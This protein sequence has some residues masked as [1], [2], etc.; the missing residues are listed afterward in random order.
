M[1]VG[2]CANRRGARRRRA[3]NSTGQF[4]VCKGR[5]RKGL[6]PCRIVSPSYLVLVSADRVEDANIAGAGIAVIRPMYMSAACQPQRKQQADLNRR[7]HR[8]ASNDRCWSSH[9][10][11]DVLHLPTHTLGS[12]T[13]PI[14]TRKQSCFLRGFADRPLQ[15]TTLNRDCRLRGFCLH[16][17]TATSW[18]PN[19]KKRI[20]LMGGGSSTSRSQPWVPNPRI[21]GQG[22]DA[23][24]AFDKLLLAQA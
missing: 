14:R 5:R 20:P 16:E 4:S 6:Q 15:S 13:P 12:T 2:N 3:E 22:H 10:P 19:Y 18:R 8:V 21:T 1:A 23:R 7:A 9:Q 24:D 17:G 11:L